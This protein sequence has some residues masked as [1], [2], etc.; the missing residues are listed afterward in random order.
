V[1]IGYQWSFSEAVLGIKQD[2]LSGILGQPLEFKTAVLWPRRTS[3]YRRN[4]WAGKVRAQDGAWILDSPVNNAAAHYLHHMLFLLG[5]ADDRSAEPASMEA[6]LYRANDIENYDT[7][8]L[9]I[10][11]GN[12]ANL[13]FLTAH[14]VDK[15]YGP[16]LH[17]EFDKAVVEYPGDNGTF[18]AKFRNGEVKSYGSPDSGEANK[19]WGAVEAVRTGK[20]PL[21]GIQ[22]AS[23][24]LVCTAAAQQA[25]IHRFPQRLIHI[26]DEYG[27]DPLVYVDGLFEDL[28]GCYHAGCLPSQRPGIAWA[29]AKTAVDLSQVV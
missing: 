19:L 10:V 21:C 5:N 14:S 8:A 15:S 3:Y 20:P 23:P 18:Q 24:H 16:L 26:Q 27:E 11:T 29:H 2:I 22:A 7:A 13:L 17:L 6:E 12:G 1:A 9:H 4:A 28:L 25:P